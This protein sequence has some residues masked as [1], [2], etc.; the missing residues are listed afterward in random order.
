M[1]EHS[2][3]RN[4]V[5]R[6]VLGPGENVVLCLDVNCQMDLALDDSKYEGEVVRDLYI[7]QTRD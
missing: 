1:I 2:G 5:N 3:I 4:H 7:L 6:A